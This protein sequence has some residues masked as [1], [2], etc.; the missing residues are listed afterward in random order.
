MIAWTRDTSLGFE[1]DV[2]QIGV[3]RLTIT[4]GGAESIGGDVVVGT[5]DGDMVAIK[6]THPECERELL[7][8]ARRRLLATGNE[9]GKVLP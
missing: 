2:A 4:I 3:F 1:R 9:L 6:G 8:V 5:I 7:R